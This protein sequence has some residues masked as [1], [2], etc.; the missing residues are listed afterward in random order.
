MRV[1]DFIREFRQTVHDHIVP[2]F[3][4]DA[5]V[6]SYL[7]EAVQEACERAKLIEDRLTPAVCSV[8]V[9]AGQAAYDLHPSVL[10]IKR[11]QLAGYPHARHRVLTETSTEEMDAT[12]CGWETRTSFPGHFIFEPATGL[13]PPR[14]RLVSTP[15]AID[16]LALTVVRGPLKPLSETRP[17]ERPE[18]PERFH[19][20]L[21]D[22]V[23]HRAYFKQDADTFD[24]AKG[25]QALALFEQSF[26][27]RPDANVQRKRRDRRP[28]VVRSNW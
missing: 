18:I 21:L 5:A 8:A 11:A 25:A 9:L 1:E 7:N 17:N 19:T 28:P 14:I 16:V 22:W 4:S 2:P 23:Y 26:G 27:V 20:R 6:V 15:N 24:P 10:Q 3:W 13:Q 12:Y